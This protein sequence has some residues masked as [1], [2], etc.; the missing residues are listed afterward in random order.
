[1]PWFIMPWLGWLTI[2]KLEYWD[3]LEGPMFPNEIF[4]PPEE[5][6]ALPLEP[7]LMPADKD[8]RLIKLAPFF[9]GSFD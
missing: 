6:P 4:W 5:D 7:D 9:Q 3:P 8:S 1:M 2:R